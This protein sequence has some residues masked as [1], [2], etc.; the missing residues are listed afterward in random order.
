MIDPDVEMT[1]QTSRCSGDHILPRIRPNLE[2]QERLSESFPP[3]TPHNTYR[4]TVTNLAI[5]QTRDVKD[6]HFGK[7]A[8][9][10]SHYQQRKGSKM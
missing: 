6:G 2:H 9:Y 1:M 4:S 5:V 8:H 7:V 3:P 10:P